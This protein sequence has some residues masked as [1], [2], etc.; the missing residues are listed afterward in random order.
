MNVAQPTSATAPR[1]LP[2]WLVRLRRLLAVPVAVALVLGAPGLAYGAFTARTT[3][4]L[5]VG[6]YKIPAPAFISGTLMCING[7]KGATITF[8]GFGLVDRATGYSAALTRSGGTTLP[9]SVRADRSE[10]VTNSGGRGTYTFTLFAKVGSWTGT[11]LEQ[12]IS[13]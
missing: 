5:G 4:A 9:Q 1:L 8:T 12:T 10:T 7:G 11:P 13:C 2:V 6:T 3:A